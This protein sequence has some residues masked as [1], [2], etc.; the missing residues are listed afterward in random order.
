MFPSN[1]LKDLPTMNRTSNRHG[2]TRTELVVALAV[3]GVL[4]V[5]AIPA[6]PGGL[7]KGKFTSTLS[8]EKQ[9]WV[10][11]SNMADDGIS[12]ENKSIG[13]PGDLV[14]SG[15]MQCKATDFVKV[16][17]KN[18]Y[19]KAG[20]LKIFSAQGVMPFKGSNVNKFSATPGPNNNCAFTI[21][22]IQQSDTG[23]SI[24]LSTINATLNVSSTTFSL[25]KY[26]AP[27]S[28]EGYVVIHKEGSGVVFRKEQATKSQF[29]GTPCKMALSG[30]AALRAE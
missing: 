23:S 16:L 18:N 13:W 26:A 24:F 8:N 7:V 1:L 30:T 10:A 19:L 22:C 12:T 20:D 2:F 21:Y 29:Q 6:M 3:V 27:F 28:D 25:D 4:A 14:A 9:I 11:T 17:I 5:L 15:T